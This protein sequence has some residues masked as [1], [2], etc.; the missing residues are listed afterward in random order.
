VQKRESAEKEK[1]RRIRRKL[2]TSAHSYKESCKED[3]P[4]PKGFVDDDRIG[5][6]SVSRD[7]IECISK[8]G[9]EESD[10]DYKFGRTTI[11]PPTKKRR[12]DELTETVNCY[13]VPK[14]CHWWSWPKLF[15][16]E[17]MRRR[18]RRRDG[19]IFLPVLG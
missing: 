14:E 4:T 11:T 12:T 9:D 15:A 13:D 7:G 10:D 5:R 18:R 2:H 8:A 17:C 16:M 1:K 19:K 3:N 6:E